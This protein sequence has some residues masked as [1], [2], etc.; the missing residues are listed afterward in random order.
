MAC[1]DSASEVKEIRKCGESRVERPTVLG[2]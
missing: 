2:A 1:Y